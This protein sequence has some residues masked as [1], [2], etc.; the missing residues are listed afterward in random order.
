MLKKFVFILLLI[1]MACVY[2]LHLLNGE[3]SI[4]GKTEEIVMEAPKEVVW[5]TLVR[6]AMIE[7]NKKDL[8]VVVLFTG[9]GWCSYCDMLEEE[10]LS[11]PGFQEL[12]DRAVFL[13]IEVSSDKKLKGLQKDLFA[14]LGIKGVPML[15]VMSKDLKEIEARIGGYSGNPG[16]YMKRIKGAL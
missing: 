5:H 2:S 3:A 1:H 7:A 11:Q 13:K 16:E 12:A 8:P 4:T 9:T 14:R 15:Y 6:D 10:V